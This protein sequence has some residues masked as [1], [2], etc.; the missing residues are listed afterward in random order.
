[1]DSNHLERATCDTDGQKE[2]AVLLDRGRRQARGHHAEPVRHL[3]AARHRSVHL[4]RG[5]AAA[6]GRALRISRGRA[7]AVAVEAALRR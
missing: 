7:R 5:R 1:M 6:R 3:P 4:P 2:L